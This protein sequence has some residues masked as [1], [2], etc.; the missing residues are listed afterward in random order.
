[1]TCDLIVGSGWPFGSEDLSEEERSR[2]VAV[3]VTKLAVLFPHRRSQGTE[4][5]AGASPF[6]GYPWAGRTSRLLSLTLV[7]DPLQSTG[8]ITDLSDRTESE[9]INIF[10]PEGNHALYALVEITGFMEVI[11]GSPGASGPVLDH[12][13]ETAVR[14]C[15]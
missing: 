11:N 6:W 4:S 15:C 14:R 7:P 9:Y 3:T 2:I 1:M 5:F 10:I 13:S 8:Q 12:F